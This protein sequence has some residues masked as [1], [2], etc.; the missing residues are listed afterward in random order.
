MSWK[1]VN[2]NCE[3]V[4]DNYIDESTV[5]VTDPPLILAIIIRDIKIK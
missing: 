1:I 4:I 3:D 5:I 2:A